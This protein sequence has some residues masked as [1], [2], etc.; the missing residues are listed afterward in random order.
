[1][2]KRASERRKRV[3]ELREQG[4]SVRAIAERVG[5]GKTTVQADLDRLARGR[6]PAR[7]YKWEDFKAGNTVALRHGTRSERAIAPLRERHLAELRERYPF[8]PRLRL[9]AQ[10][11]RLAQIDLA[12]RWLDEVDEI[13][14]DDE[15][16]IFPVASELVK[17]L[18][19]AEQW[20]D[21]AEAELKE[22]SKFDALSEFMSEGEEVADGDDS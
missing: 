10:S 13:V 22:R 6:T 7:G 11:Q 19:T 17:W 12:S 9:A 18:G 21:R 15:G 5:C 8:M 2:K 20:F 1:M 4:L 3:G 14:K 16:R